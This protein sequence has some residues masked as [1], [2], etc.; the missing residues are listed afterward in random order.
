MAKDYAKYRTYRQSRIKH[1]RIW[2]ML[3]L[4]L[5]LFIL[6]LFAAIPHHK[7]QVTRQ[8]EVKL[9]QKILKIP[10]S[11][12]Q[13]SEPK[14]DFYNILAQDDSSSKE[15]AISTKDTSS[16]NANKGIAV[17]ISSPFKNT[18]ENTPNAQPEQVAI[19]EVKKQIN[20]ELKQIANESYFLELGKFQDAQQAEQQ[21]AQALLKG[22]N[23]HSTLRRVNGKKSYW[24]FMGPYR[25]RSMAAEQQARLREVGIQSILLKANL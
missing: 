16:V 5:I 3:A 12:P 22:F 17:P 10:I 2:L 15:T 11:T 13:P 23:V 24:L 6:G 7:K 1:G 4:T 9:K 8:M 18:Q 21:Q 20:Q 25:A 14:F 19:A